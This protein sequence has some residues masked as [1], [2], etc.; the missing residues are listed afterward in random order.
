MDTAFAKTS[1]RCLTRKYSYIKQ[2]T[3]VT[4][5]W[6]FSNKD[7]GRL[8]STGWWGNINLHILVHKLLAAIMLK[9]IGEGNE[10]VW[11]LGCVCVVAGGEL[12]F[13]IVTCYVLSSR[14]RDYRCYIL[15]PPP[16]PF[17]SPR[18]K[19]EIMQFSPW[20]MAV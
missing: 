20:K 14:V 19:M 4:F 9:W 2:N 16:L 8:V 12:Q 18:T 17:L 11:V 10:C 13:H 3:C 7:K 1:S 6:K 5:K 15:P